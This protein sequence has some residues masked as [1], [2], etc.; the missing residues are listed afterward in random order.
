MLNYLVKRLF[1][2]VL[3]AIAVSILAFSLLR[4]SGDPAI[5]IAGEGAR[6]AEIELVRKTYGF[7]RPLAVQYGRW[8][9]D[10]VRGELGT[11]LY[12]KTEVGPLVWAKLQVTLALGLASLCLALA[13]SVPLGVLAAIYKNSWIDR[14]CLAAA[15]VG[16]ALPNFFFRA[17]ARHGVFDFAALASGLGQR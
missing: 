9:Y 2:A 4:L 16:Q 13:I 12:F 8:A 1:V 3:V 17:V 10:L 6:E 5:A 7:D 11:S 14:L 15:V